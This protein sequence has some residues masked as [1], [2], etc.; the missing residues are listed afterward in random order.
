MVHSNINSVL[1]IFNQ[2]RSLFETELDVLVH[3]ETK[4]DQFN[5]NNSSKPYRIDKNKHG[6]GIVIQIDENK[7]DIE[8]TFI[9]IF[10][11]KRNDSL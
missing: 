2:F 11:R 1:S 5:L 6:R 10:F 8:N 3:T 9:E 7:N 4:I